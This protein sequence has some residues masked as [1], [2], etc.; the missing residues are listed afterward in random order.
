MH[1]LTC[2]VRQLNT[3]GFR[4]VDSPPDPL[5]KRYEF[6]N[7]YFRADHPELLKYIQR[8]KSSKRDST[9]ID[10]LDDLQRSPLSDLGNDGNGV[11]TL[12]L[13]ELARLQKQNDDTQL[14]LKKVAEE[15]SVWKKARIRFCIL[16]V[17]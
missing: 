16:Y 5:Q 15:V 11:N 2:F 9:E 14:V 12:L 10:L 17:V 6:H 3:Y 1:I 8:R 7:R 13:A 4:K